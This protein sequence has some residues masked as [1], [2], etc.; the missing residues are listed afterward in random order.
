[1]GSASPRW[2]TANAGRYYYFSMADRTAPQP[3]PIGTTPAPRAG[4]KLYGTG[5]YSRA[6]ARGARGALNG[7]SREAK[8]I[9]AYEA[10]LIEHVG[11]RPTIVQRALITRAARLACHL[12]IWD[13]RTIPE[14]GAFTATGHN[15]Y[16]AWS[17]ALTRTLARL[18]IDGAAA[19]SPTLAEAMATARREREAAA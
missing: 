4:S 18:G 15:H 17:N 6:L 5:P 12:E 3:V 1:M 19:R 13:Q 7:N 16:L 8:F 9:Q 14:G 11:G 2:Q 10:L